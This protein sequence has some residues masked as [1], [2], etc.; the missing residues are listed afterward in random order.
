MSTNETQ[1]IYIN[2][3]DSGKLS[4]K[5]KIA[6]YG[7]IVFLSKR[8]KDKFI[9]QYRKIINDIKCDYCK[10]NKNKCSNKC[11][12]VKNTNVKAPDR[13]RLINYIKK[14]YNIALIIKNEDIYDYIITNKASKGRF[15]DYAIRRLIKETIKKLIKIGKINPNIS[16][17]I[18]LNIDQQS[19]KSNGYYNLKDGLIEELVHGIINFNYNAIHKPVLYGGLEVILRYHDSARSYAVQAADFMAG[20]IRKLALDNLNDSTKFY[21]EIDYIDFKLNLP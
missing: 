6:V 16:V 3:D 2:L 14:Y 13:R 7:G 4:E 20:N 21:E 8:E 11:P 15:M 18:I 10:N 19:T 9:T 12:E 5:E 1:E 17:R